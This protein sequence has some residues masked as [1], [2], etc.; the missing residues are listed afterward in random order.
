MHQKRAQKPA[1]KRKNFRSRRQN[2]GDSLTHFKPLGLKET[3]SL[4]YSLLKL[5]LFELFGH[6][7][8]EQV[9]RIPN[10]PVESIE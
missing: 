3:D 5:M 4:L 1:P 7:D 8:L 6:I 10:F 2:I 9:N